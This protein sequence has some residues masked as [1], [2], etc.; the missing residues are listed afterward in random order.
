MAAMRGMAAAVLVGDTERRDARDEDAG[1]DRQVLDRLLAGVGVLPGTMRIRRVRLNGE[2]EPYQPGDPRRGGELSEA[3][4][5]AIGDETVIVDPVPERAPD[6]RLLTLMVP[7]RR[8]DQMDLLVVE[9]HP[10]GPGLSE[11]EIAAVFTLRDVAATALEV[12]ETRAWARIDPLTRCLNHG[13]MHDQL[14]EEIARARRQSGR[15]ACVMLDLD[16]FKSVN[17]RHGHRAGDGILRAVSAAM[18]LECRQ[19]DVCCR[20]GG[21]EFVLILPDVGIDAA[22]QTAERLR[23]AVA[24]SV[25]VHEGAAIRLTATAAVADWRGE[26]ATDLLARVDRALMLGK[27]GGGDSIGRG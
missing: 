2:D 7:L 11:L 21:D 23:G 24:R 5:S 20:Y 1:P 18:R 6:G 14:E 4:R 9:S 13:A 16:D 27:G 26:S 17:D 19:Y 15:L 22:V 8:T 10:D 12:L 25:I 3:M